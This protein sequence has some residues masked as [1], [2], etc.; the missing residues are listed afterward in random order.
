LGIAMRRAKTVGEPKLPKLVF[1][2]YARY[3]KYAATVKDVM[4]TSRKLP[5]AKMSVQEFIDMWV[6]PHQQHYIVINEPNKLAGV[7][8]LP[9]LRHLPKNSWKETTLGNVV[10]RYTAVAW[11]DEP[12]DD[13]LERMANNNM[14]MIPV[15]S[16]DTGE[17]I[18]SISSSDI[19]TRI[20]SPR[21]SSG[22]SG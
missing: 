6:V 7:V 10:S 16:H 4:D 19:M 21:E 2:S 3:V 13:V 18:G 11:P 22:Q 5:S 12:L 15:I 1:P 14:S 20:I 9:N 8:Y 17:I